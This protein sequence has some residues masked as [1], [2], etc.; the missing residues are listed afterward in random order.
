MYKRF[1][2]IILPIMLISIAIVWG[3]QL[4]RSKSGET[5]YITSDYITLNTISDL[6]KQSDLVLLGT[7]TK[8]EDQQFNTARNT[9]DPS[10]PATDLYIKGTIYNIQVEQYLKGAGDPEIHIFQSENISFPVINGVVSTVYV[11]DDF[12]PISVDARYVFFLKAADTYP[13]SP[14]PDLYSG[15]AE[16]YR[17]RIENGVATAESPS[18]LARD[19]YPMEKESI[20]LEEIITALSK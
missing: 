10:L 20:L 14:Y 2:I 4:F 6:T 16:P 7:V 9:R 5:A 18:R 15:T 17:F 3:V 11:T 12:I 19:Q 8:I 1:F 13:D